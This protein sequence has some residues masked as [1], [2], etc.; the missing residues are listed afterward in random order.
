[1][2]KQTSLCVTLSRAFI[3][4][5]IWWWFL[6]VWMNGR[7]LN[8]ENNFHAATEFFF[9]GITRFDTW[10]PSIIFLR[11]KIAVIFHSIFLLLNFKIWSTLCARSRQKRLISWPQQFHLNESFSVYFSELR[12]H[13][14]PS[15]HIPKLFI[16]K[17][18]QKHF[19]F[20]CCN[21]SS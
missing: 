12:F 6:I 2:N 18:L 14:V 5:R 16:D 11:S 13:F 1:M 17:S 10:I 8:P 19:N 3:S 4:P 21:E 7:R 15:S 20:F 9:I